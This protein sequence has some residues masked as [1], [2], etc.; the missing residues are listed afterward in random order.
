MR[1]KAL[2]SR[3]R[4]RPWSPEAS[5]I[6]AS[7]G[8]CRREGGTEKD[9]ELSRA[10]R[11]DELALRHIPLAIRVAKRCRRRELPDEDLLAEAI[12]ALLEVAKRW[13]PD[14]GTK[15][16]SYAQLWIVGRLLRSTREAAPIHASHKRDGMPAM[17]FFPDLQGCGVYVEPRD[18]HA[19]AAL[20]ARD[21]VEWLQRV[22]T[23]YERRLVALYWGLGGKEA[24]TY[25]EVGKSLSPPRTGE[26]VR[27]LVSGAMA[28]MQQAWSAAPV[29][30]REAG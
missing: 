29:E 2:P 9:R 5:R 16:S 1:F 21:T 8:D 13:D 24:M 7:F 28:K 18:G 26:R 12:A 27:Q 3:M 30:V 25:A 19:V 10:G 15:F 23:S 17:F 11:Y 20:V 4:T 6:I 14:F 22:L